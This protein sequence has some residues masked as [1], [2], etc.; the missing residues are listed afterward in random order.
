MFSGKKNSTFVTLFSVEST[1]KNIELDIENIQHKL[2][3]LS[4][5]SPLDREQIEIELES[6]KDSLEY[7][8]QILKEL[9]Q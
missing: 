2:S 5:S 4:N 8:K 6:K 1:I 3:T 7:F 9:K